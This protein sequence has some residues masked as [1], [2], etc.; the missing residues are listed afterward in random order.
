MN[1]ANKNENLIAMSHGLFGNGCK[2][3]NSLEEVLADK[4]Y[5]YDTI[6]MRYKSHGGGFCQ[7]FV[8]IKDCPKL[9]TEW[10]SKGAKKELI[11]FNADDLN[12]S[13]IL[14]QGEVC[15]LDWELHLRFSQVKEPM[16][17]AFSKQ[18][19]NIKGLAAK[20]LLQQHLYPNSFTD[21]MALLELYPNHVIE[22]TTYDYQV[23]DNER[24]NTIIWEVRNY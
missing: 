13:C 12:E 1:I 21:V 16:R 19:E 7:Y 18:V 14:L 5:S 17:I 6:T 11:Y 9:I 4:S 2:H 24:R 3:W 10:E 22:F 20:M 8:P 15:E 23:G